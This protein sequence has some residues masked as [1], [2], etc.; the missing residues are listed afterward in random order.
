MFASTFNPGAGYTVSPI[1]TDSIADRSGTVT[2]GATAQQVAGANS[3][4][5]GFF[6]QNTSVGDLW[7]SEVGI[8]TAASPSFRIPAGE[9]FSFPATP[10]AAV[11]VYGATTGQAFT[12]REW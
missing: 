5:R 10:S 12:A 2:T 11:S 9:A 8:A 7:V 6:L 1:N 3:F 4:R